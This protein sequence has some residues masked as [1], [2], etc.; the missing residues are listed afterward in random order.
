MKAADTRKPGEFRTE[1]RPSLDGATVW[2]I[3]ESRVDSIGVVVGDVGAEEPAKVVLAQDDDVIDELAL[4]G[5]DPS[6]R[7]TVLPWAPECCPFRRDAKRL[8]RLRDFVRE[9]RVIVE[10]QVARC[11]FV[12]ER[13]AELLADPRSCRTGRNIEMD[14][15]TSRRRSR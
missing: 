1:R 4:A 14:D 2:C 11:G 12:G 5:S 8:D 6:L 15:P 7:R 3:S 10:D 13:L 9:N